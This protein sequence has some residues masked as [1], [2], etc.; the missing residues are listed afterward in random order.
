MHHEVELGVV[1]GKAGKFISQEEA[2]EHVAGYVLA[3]DMTARDI[4]R[5]HQAKKWP[6]FL[7]NRFLRPSI[8]QKYEIQIS[9]RNRILK[10]GVKTW[11]KILA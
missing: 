1:I 7:S 6:C 10:F 11:I 3:I 8:E 5:I 9:L 2:M 4:Q